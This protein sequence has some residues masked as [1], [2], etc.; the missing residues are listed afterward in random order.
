MADSS[1][2]QEA[3]ARG[4]ELLSSFEKQKAQGAVPSQV[5]RHSRDTAGAEDSAGRPQIFTYSEWEG[6]KPRVLCSVFL[7]KGSKHD[8]SF[9]LLHM[10]QLF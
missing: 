6:T 5:T 10:I 1:G 3:K 2:G 9:L 4:C 8:L 7:L